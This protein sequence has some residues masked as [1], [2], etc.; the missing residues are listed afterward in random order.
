MTRCLILEDEPL[1]QQV[2]AGYLG[3]TAGFELAGICRN[4]VEAFEFLHRE[5]IDLLFLDI[6]MPFM[7]GMD[8]IRAL[9]SPPAVIFTTAFPDYAAES[10]ELRAIDYLLKPVTYERFLESIGKF[11]RWHA[12]VMEP[13]KDHTFFKVNGLFIRLE[14][15][16]ILFAQSVKDYIV[17]HTLSETHITHMTMKYLDELLPASVFLRVHRSFLINRNKIT[18]IGKQE[19]GLGGHRIP[20]G[21][22]YRKVI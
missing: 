20:I 5:H 21:K 1:A 6:R 3:K 11:S 7:N 9:K 13:E 18:S 19:I 15:H 14:H 17:I 12:P 10:Y 8:F 2:I 16:E 22:N 4:A